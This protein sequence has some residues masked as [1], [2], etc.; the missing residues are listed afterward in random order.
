MDVFIGLVV[1]E[2]V[3]LGQSIRVEES[4]RIRECLTES[5]G[6][7]ESFRL[8]ES[9][10]V[11]KCIDVQQSLPVVQYLAVPL[12]LGVEESECVDQSLGQSVRQY[13][14]DR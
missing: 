3:T 8:P 6:L 7:P 12:D 14:R 2:S 4:K 1:T 11:R 10:V 13:L 5:V 9:V